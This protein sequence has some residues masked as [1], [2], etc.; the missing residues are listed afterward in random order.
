MT[1][2]L[3]IILLSCLPKCIF[4]LQITK[5]NLPFN[6]YLGYYYVDGPKVHLT[7]LQLLH[8]YVISHICHY[9]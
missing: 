1:H 7:Y 2:K 4:V 6:N 8:I 9:N 3:L 5:K